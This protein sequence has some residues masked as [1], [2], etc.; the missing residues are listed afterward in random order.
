MPE[1]R[2]IFFILPVFKEGGAEKTLSTI[3]GGMVERGFN[4]TLVII[5]DNISFPFPKNV[6]TEVLEK[7]WMAW[8]PE[9]FK[10]AFYCRKIKSIVSKEEPM[11]VFASLPY[12]HKIVSRTGI[13][14]GKLF[15]TVHNTPSSYLSSK[16]SKRVRDLRRLKAIYD[17]QNIV[18]ISEGVRDDMITVGVL[19]KNIVTIYN[20]FDFDEIQE[21]ASETIPGIPDEPFLVYPAHFYKRKRHDILIEALSLSGVKEK[22]VL[23]GSRGEMDAAKA[24]VEK[25][26]LED[27]VIFAGWHANPYPWIKRAKLL[28]FASEQEGLGRALIESL[29]LGTPVVSTDCPSGPSE[30]LT[31]TLK[32]FLVPVNDPHALAEKIKEALREYPQITPADTEKFEKEHVISQ[33]VALVLKESE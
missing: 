6:E 32:P 4:V 8:L 28:V 20:P 31:G 12:A 9:I 27:Q 2:K 23:L 18:T 22:L 10:K 26:G 24:L 5:K 25:K 7:K 15:F 21:K 14:M 33:Y 30:I 1:N 29:V 11:A 16:P 13:A 17:G 3:M 19:P